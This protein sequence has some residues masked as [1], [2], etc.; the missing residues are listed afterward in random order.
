MGKTIRLSAAKA[1]NVT[2]AAIDVM[3]LNE[4]IVMFEQGWSDRE[5]I[6]E[7]KWVKFL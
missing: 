5:W 3:L 6:Y 2:K 1:T 7:G 4:R